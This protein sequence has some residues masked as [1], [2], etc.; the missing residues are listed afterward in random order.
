M[1]FF[2]NPLYLNVQR[3]I[4]HTHYFP[5]YLIGMITVLYYGRFCHGCCRRMANVSSSSQRTIHC[6]Y[7]FRVLPHWILVRYP[8][9]NF[10]NNYNN[11]QLTSYIMF[12]GW[13]IL[14]RVVQL[15]CSFWIC[16]TV[17]CL[18]RSRFHFMVLRS[19]NTF[20]LSFCFL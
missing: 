20:L 9:K 18:L 4:L 17:P 19:V 1:H 13:H 16:T 7:M 12:P 6:W 11:K 8:S 2:L 15:L 3:T 5:F 10:Q 14:V